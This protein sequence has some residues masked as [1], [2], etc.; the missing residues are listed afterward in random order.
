VYRA[1]TVLAAI[2]VAT[3]AAAAAPTV[4]V[5]A[6]TAIELEPVRRVTGGIAVSGALVDTS[7]R[8][9]VPWATMYLSLDDAQVVAQSK[10][11]GRFGAQ[12]A[13]TEG[14]HTL[15]VR[16]PGDRSYAA[17]DAA[18]E[19]FDVSKDRVALAVRASRE[20]E[21]GGQ[22]IRIAVAARTDGGP[23]DI[24]VDLGLAD[25]DGRELEL[26]RIATVDGRGAASFA[27]EQLGRPGRKRIIARFAGDAAYDVATAET[28][29]VLTAGTE[30]SLQLERTALKFEARLAGR[31]RLVDAYGNPVAGARVSL[32]AG[33]RR[34]ADA[35]TGDDGRFALG[36]Q[37]SELGE[38]Q[39]VVQAR[40]EAAEAWSKS[41]RS[42]PVTI[43]VRPPQPVPTGYTL[44]AFAATSVAVAVF[45]LL[46][47]RP[48]QTLLARLRGGRD[49]ARAAD[50]GARSDHVDS[51]PAVE[52]IE[53]GL[54]HARPGLV[55]SL[56][57]PHDHGFSGVVHDAITGRPL[58]GVTVRIGTADGARELR[59]DAAGR[60]DFGELP[61]GSCAGTAALAT[62]CTEQF[63][64]ELPHRGELRGARIALLEV[65]ERL[66]R[67]YRDAAQPLLPD[68]G[69]W[70]IWTPRHIVDHVR[71]RRPAPALAELT[72]FIEDAYF[73]QRKPGEDQ[74]A[75]AATRV[76]AAI[77]ERQQPP[78]Q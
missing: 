24:E 21:V 73:S 20:V 48:W 61:A 64:V 17:A 7:L 16:F 62:Y 27:A 11:D 69:H 6:R 50:A 66:F 52:A 68:P 41:S 23:V 5:R 71:A 26:G 34:V 1:V 4:T 8:A 65:R 2:A 30:L 59:T 43:E 58:A 55:S 13:V 22:P 45:V 67:M 29:L 31:G 63:P 60:F 33:N 75:C 57:R 42:P 51:L 38:G 49:A 54:R 25:D 76:H 47:A 28:E 72:D 15:R 12:F 44:A 56:R 18:L 32:F 14:V 77:L 46:R 37:A 40:F 9:P 70:G 78:L 35:L 10:D 53:A 3:A 19:A 74:I 36:V 39:L